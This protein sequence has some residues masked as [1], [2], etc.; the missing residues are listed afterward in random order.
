[1]RRATPTPCMIRFRYRIGAYTYILE[2]EIAH[3]CELIDRIMRHFRGH[4]QLYETHLF[5]AYPCQLSLRSC[6]IRS[7]ASCSPWAAS[8]TPSC[9]VLPLCTLLELSRQSRSVLP[10]SIG[11]ITETYGRARGTESP[12]CTTLPLEGLCVLS[13][14]YLC[15][16]T[17]ERNERGSKGDRIPKLVDEPAPM[18]QGRLGRYG[19]ESKL[20]APLS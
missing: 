11:V 14:Y 8:H 19:T 18:T 5:R 2:L 6:I 12:S 13:G 9:P 4:I 16:G 1:M 20:G 7:R 10:T 3:L 15:F 17:A